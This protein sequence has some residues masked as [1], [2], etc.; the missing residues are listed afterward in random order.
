MSEGPTQA[1]PVG[2]K[3]VSRR[4]F[5]ALGGRLGQWGAAM[6]SP[7]RIKAKLHRIFE[8]IRGRNTEPEAQTSFVQATAAGMAAPLD[9][10]SRRLAERPLDDESLHGVVAAASKPDATETRTAV[11]LA[12]L[13]ILRREADAAGAEAFVRE[14]A[15]GRMTLMQVVEELAKSLEAKRR[16]ENLRTQAQEEAAAVAQAVESLE[17]SVTEIY[18]LVLGR[19]ADTTGFAHYFAELSAGRMTLI[20]VM[21]NLLASEEFAQTVLRWPEVARAVTHSAL[22]GLTQSEPDPTT[23]NRYVNALMTGYPIEAFI[24]EFVN[25]KVLKPVTPEQDVGI[26]ARELIIANL[27]AQGARISLAPL[28]ADVAPV[29]PA[30]LSRLMMTLAMLGEPFPSVPQAA[31]FAI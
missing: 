5:A 14:I 26:L 30:E 21:A 13:A 10:R 6:R 24:G 11:N 31:Q 12:Y 29:T 3:G 17:Q 15:E 27:N 19:D 25:A 8:V 9:L 7:T 23:V 20:Q 28:N 22:R 4:V 18:Q 16:V 1:E 2:A